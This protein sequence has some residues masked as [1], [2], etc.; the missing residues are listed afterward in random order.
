[1]NWLSL[2]YRFASQIHPQNILAMSVN[3]LLASFASV[4]S[5][6]ALQSSALLATVPLQV[7]EVEVTKVGTPEVDLA[8]IE[9]LSQTTVCEETLTFAIGPATKF[10]TTVNGRTHQQTSLT[11]YRGYQYVTYI[12]AQR[13]VCI[14][15]RQLQSGPWQ[16]IQFTDHKFETN[17]SH[18]TAV[19][20]ICDK[21]G[22]IHMAF[23]HHATQLN[24][25]VSNLGAAHSPE[26]TP[27]KADLFGPVLHTLGSVAPDPRVT[28]P[29][30]FS[31]PNGNL[32]LFYRGV[33]SGDG[34][35][36]IEEYDGDQHDWSVGLGK[37]I[38]R[39]IGTFTAPDGR[40]SLKR[41]PYMNS[42]S[43]AGERLHASWIWRDR[44][45]KTNARNQHDLCYAYSDNHGRTW[46][47]SDGKEIGKT[48]K[49][50]IHLDSPGVVV[51]S[52]PINSSLSNQNT[53]YAYEDG[54]IHVV[55]R[56]LSKGTDDGYYHHYWRN[57]QGKWNQETLPFSGSRPKLV[58]TKDRSLILAYTDEDDDEQEELFVAHGQPNADR[59]SWQ[60]TDVKL[61]RRH[62]IT[63]EA[64]LD[65]ERWEK[66]RVLSIYGQEEPSK[67]VETKLPG[68][69][70]GFPAPLNV[71]DYQFAEHILAE[72]KLIRPPT[73]RL[74]IVVDGNSPD[75]D[76]IGATA[77][78]FGLLKASGLSDRLVHLSHSCD[79][80]PVAKIS[81]EDE[82]RR[83][84]V[85]DQ[86]CVDGQLHFGPFE[87]LERHFNCRT[88]QNPAV[89]HLR[90]AINK[91]SKQD[92]L[93]IIEAGEPDIIGFALA[94]AKPTSRRY[95]HVVSH[96]PANDNSGD[97]FKWQQILDFG[98]TE[99]Q[100]GDQNVGLQ[101]AIGAWDWAKQHSNAGIGWIWNRLAYA[102][103]DGVVKFQTNK[104]DCSDAGMLYWWITGAA[105]GGNKLATPT[106]IAGMLKRLSNEQ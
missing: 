23:D 101:T 69:V 56:H 32:M 70:D 89:E 93:W 39:D 68:P 99:H 18:N 82:Q 48:G 3:T 64:I 59:T 8:E 27:W 87:K 41:C 28:Y 78:I 98:V 80:R 97:F 103:Q 61:P 49:E 25:R 65:L 19:I 21:D 46:M 84:Q 7:D 26:S 51:A 106:E 73:G 43:Y 79:L 54:S 90:D 81:A 105:Q 14:G 58:G 47:N 11:T 34:D 88:Q 50:F 83:Q 1:M 37:V 12:D 52:I 74:A 22:T 2:C 9:L 38:A 104:F 6:L 35:G 63:G 71:I 96:H 55:L 53:H 30:F 100:I 94:A 77:V 40:V 45:E 4:L 102:E 29:R 67:I 20:G 62:S 5:L 17:D 66:E 42:V 92:P 36:V 91:S 24:Y 76:D 13:R 16:I 57:S 95:V 10:S 60:W 75:P 44:F 31:A 86:L 85:L 33:T 72:D 15:R